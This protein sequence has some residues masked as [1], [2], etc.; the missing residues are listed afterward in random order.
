MAPIFLLAAG[1]CILLLFSALALF[2]VPVIVLVAIG[3]RPGSASAMLQASWGII[4]ARARR[5]G[6]DTRVEYLFL[7]RP[8]HT[9]SGGGRKAPPVQRPEGKRPAPSTLSWAWLLLRLIKPV[10]SFGDR[11]LHATTL[12]EARGRLRVGVGDPVET[13]LLFGRYC[14]LAPLLRVNRIYLDL[15]PVFDRQVLEGEVAAR[16]RIDRPLLLILAGAGL[17]LNRDVRAA[18]S[19]SQGGVR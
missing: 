16:L 5:E 3:R 8:I 1:V 14:A 4:G 9:R 2:L 12:L 11:L 13:G 6:G 18:L 17:L 7:G 19:V 15:S 10:S